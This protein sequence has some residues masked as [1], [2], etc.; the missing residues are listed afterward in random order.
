MLRFKLIAGDFLT[1]AQ[2]R[3][4]IWNLDNTVQLPVHGKNEFP[5][6]LKN[7]SIIYWIFVGWLVYLTHGTGPK[8]EIVPFAD[9]V[10]F[11]LKQQTVLK[12]DKGEQEN[13][14]SVQLR[15]GRKF[16][17]KGNHEVTQAFEAMAF[18]SN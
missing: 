17:A 14:F 3:A 4:Q 18:N 15:D 16:L 11:E 5:E 12:T 6:T 7:R 9:I 8:I 10:H 1:E 2:D 13:T